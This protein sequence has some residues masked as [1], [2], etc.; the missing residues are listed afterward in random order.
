MIA[1]Y[2]S[3]GI[4]FCLKARKGKREL[5]ALLVS[6]L[7]KKDPSNVFSSFYGHNLVKVLWHRWKERLNIRKL[8]K[9]ESDAAFKESEDIAP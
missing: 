1:G 3:G 5:E 6:M 7:K 9:F 2:R 8:A 4:V